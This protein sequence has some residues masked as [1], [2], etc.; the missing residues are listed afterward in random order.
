MAKGDAQSDDAADAAAAKK[1]KMM[2][3]VG[4][5]VVAAAAYFFVFSGGSADAEA[6][7]PT[8]TIALSEEA[9]GAILPV[10]A[11][12]VNLTDETPHFARVAFSVVLVEGTDPLVVEAKFP[13][14]LDAALRELADFTSVELRTLAGQER[15]REALSEQAAALLNDEEEGVRLVTRVVLT[16][17]L[18]Q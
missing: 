2:M 3:G 4:G 18:V 15:L 16:D 6:M 11:L 14:M 10:G 17:L 1:K 12:T 7:A 8:T 13:L 5:L 9:E